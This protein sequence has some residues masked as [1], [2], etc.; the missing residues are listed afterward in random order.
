MPEDWDPTELE[1]YVRTIDYVDGFTEKGR[2][3]YL[4]EVDLEQLQNADRVEVTIR[5]P[6][7]TEDTRWFGG[8][9]EDYDDVW[10]DVIEWVED[11][12]P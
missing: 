10:Y 6:D 9:W 2:D 3:D 8:P 11:G 1:L 5:Y 12:T 7:G 4:Y